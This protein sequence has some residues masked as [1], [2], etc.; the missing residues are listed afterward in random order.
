MI[1]DRTVLSEEFIAT[2]RT[3]VRE[4]LAERFTDDDFIFD[5]IVVS[6]RIDEYGPDATDE[7]YLVISIVYDGDRKN[8][9][10]SWTSGMI[11]RLHRKLMAVGIYYDVAPLWVEKS[12][13]EAILRRWRRKHPEEAARATT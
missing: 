12:E 7:E 3:I 2:V 6:T 4:T 5:P 9:D 13:Y 10:S 11:G 8:L 1:K